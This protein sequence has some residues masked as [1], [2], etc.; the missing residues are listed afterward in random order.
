MMSTWVIAITVGV[1]LFIWGLWYWANISKEE[2]LPIEPEAEVAREN[3]PPS[4]ESRF[5]QFVDEERANFL[6]LLKKN[7]DDEKVFLDKLFEEK[8]VKLINERVGKIV[9][10]ETGKIIDKKVGKIIEEKTV[11]LFEENAGKIESKLS[12]IEEKM[13]DKTEKISSQLEE[14]YRLST[15]ILRDLGKNQFP[16]KYVQRIDE[17]AQRLEAQTATGGKNEAQNQDE[18]EFFFSRL[19][20]KISNLQKSISELAG[21]R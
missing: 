10:E 17:L 11:R 9:E 12:T 2:L 3:P 1:I 5:R 7:W 19:N 8:L 14:I 18:L 21:N 16:E 4:E 15:E 13:P 20:E 6:S